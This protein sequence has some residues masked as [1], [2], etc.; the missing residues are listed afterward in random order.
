MLAAETR[1]VILD[2]I[3]ALPPAQREVIVLRDVEGMASADVCN[4]LAITDTHQRVLL[5]RA[6]SRIR[7]ALEQ[8][9]HPNAR[10]PRVADPGSAATEAT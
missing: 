10:T 5:H 3:E 7:S 1:T 2:A 8:Y 9:Y 6:R 4:I